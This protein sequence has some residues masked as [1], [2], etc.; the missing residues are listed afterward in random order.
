MCRVLVL[1]L[2]GTISMMSSPGGYVCGPPG[3]LASMCRQV[4][5]LHDASFDLAEMADDECIL[6]TPVSELGGRA[7]FKIVDYDP[8]LDSSNMQGGF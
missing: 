7:L 2:G 6:V 8:L 3:F 1:N 5:M 4:P